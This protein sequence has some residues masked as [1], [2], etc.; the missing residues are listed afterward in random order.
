MPVV[1]PFAVSVLQELCQGLC[2]V[3][4]AHPEVLH[5]SKCINAKLGA[6]VNTPF[7][8]YEREKPL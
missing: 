6:G 7:I 1:Q 5:F 8:D 4:M 3:Y 2:S